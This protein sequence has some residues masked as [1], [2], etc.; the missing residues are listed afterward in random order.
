MLCQIELATRRGSYRPRPSIRLRGMPPMLRVG[1][2]EPTNSDAASRRTVPMVARLGYR[3]GT[4]R[5]VA[6]LGSAPALG[7]GGRQFKSD[8]P[9]GRRTLING[10]A[11]G[12]GRFRLADPRRASAIFSPLA[13]WR[14][15]RCR[16]RSCRPQ[17]SAGFVHR[18]RRLPNLRPSARSL[19]RSRG[20]LGIADRRGRR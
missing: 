7:A 13:S 9:D 10:Y 2:V 17:E 3:P 5:A 4:H 14:G 15:A 8:Q 20:S 16:W 11:A 18:I 1:G 19:P 12:G 6:Q